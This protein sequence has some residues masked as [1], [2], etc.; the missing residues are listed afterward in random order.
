MFNLNQTKG[1]LKIK[2][3]TIFLLESS[4]SLKYSKFNFFLGIYPLFGLARLKPFAN[5]Y[6]SPAATLQCWGLLGEEKHNFMF[7][8]CHGGVGL[9]LLW[10]V[11]FFFSTILSKIGKR[12]IFHMVF[13]VLFLNASMN[14]RK[15]FRDSVSYCV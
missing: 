3:Q 7:Q 8:H 4:I 13:G 6:S 1:I 5:R 14:F 9:I 12:R 11:I 15:N 10:G 2:L